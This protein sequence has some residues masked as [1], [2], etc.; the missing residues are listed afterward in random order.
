MLNVVCKLYTCAHTNLPPPPRI[1][2]NPILQP[3]LAFPDRPLS[4]A[5]ITPLRSY[6]PPAWYRNVLLKRVPSPRVRCSRDTASLNNYTV[7]RGPRREVTVVVSRSCIIIYERLYGKTAR[8]NFG[9]SFSFVCGSKAHFK[10]RQPCTYTLYG[11]LYYISRPTAAALET[12]VRFGESGLRDTKSF[13]V[14]SQLN[15]Y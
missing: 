4:S 14:I 3:R 5:R 2:R 6:L 13:R 9:F 12:A 10:R 7:R 11:R 15:S 8:K 1:D